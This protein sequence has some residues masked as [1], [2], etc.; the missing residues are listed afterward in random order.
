MALQHISEPMKGAL[1]SIRE[2]MWKQPG[3]WV[4][5]GGKVRHRITQRTMSPAR[6]RQDRLPDLIELALRQP[7]DELFELELRD[8]VS[9]LRAIRDA[10]Q[11]PPPPEAG[12][13]AVP[14]RA[15]A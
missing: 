13:V 12:A 1:A 9:M 3:M 14:E 7:D 8:L 4:S 10:E 5:V 6:A 15:A 2:A 11:S